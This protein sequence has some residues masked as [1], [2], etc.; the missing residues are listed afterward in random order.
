MRIQTILAGL[1]VGLAATGT[2]SAGSSWFASSGPL[3]YQV[4][5]TSNVNAPIAQP[6]DISSRLGFK[7]MNFIPPFRGV[8]NTRNYGY[9]NFPTASQLPAGDYLK[10]FNFSQPGR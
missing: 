6:Q 9:S 4:V 10:S 5:D 2:A 1:V 8:S 7:L 3:Q